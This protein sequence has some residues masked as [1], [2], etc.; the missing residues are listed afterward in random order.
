MIRRQFVAGLRS[1]EAWI[2]IMC[3]NVEKIDLCVQIAEHADVIR[4]DLSRRKTIN[5]SSIAL[6]P[7]PTPQQYPGTTEQPRPSSQNNGAS[8][9]VYIPPAPLYASQSQGYS[10]QAP[11]SQNPHYLPKSAWPELNPT[12]PMVCHGCKEPGYIRKNRP[13]LNAPS[14]DINVSNFAMQPS[15]SGTGPRTNVLRDDLSPSAENKRV[16]KIIYLL[17]IL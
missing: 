6:P 17:I 4:E 13:Y 2:K 9:N 11:T 16:K 1:L 8:W 5:L 10:S 14:Y 15:K 3:D 7:P 12:T